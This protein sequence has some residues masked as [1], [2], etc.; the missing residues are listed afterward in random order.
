[1]TEDHE[2]ILGT[3]AAE[4]ERLG[5]QHHVWVQHMLAVLDFAGIRAGDVVLDVGCGPGFTTFELAHAVGQRGRVI[6]LDVSERFLEHLRAACRLRALTNVEPMLGTAEEFELPDGS[7]D[8]AYSRWVLCWLARPED[9]LARVAR[10]LRPGGAFIVQDYLDWGAK[11]LVPRSAAHD[12]VVQACLRSW[13]L[14][15]GTI[16]IGEHLPTLAGRCGLVVEHFQPIARSG[17]G[18][19]LVWRWLETFYNV[20]LPRL[21]ERGLLEASAAADFF[22]D[23]ERRSNDGT[24]RV[25]TPTM[26]DIVMRKV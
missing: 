22:A 23:W 14:G 7:L 8:A 20:Y 1:M 24:S 4:L 16:D 9:A 17:S 15:G 21:V 11:K 6:A 26:V 2:Y 19:S 3:H 18:G 12:G 25:V 13:S 10:A 5:F